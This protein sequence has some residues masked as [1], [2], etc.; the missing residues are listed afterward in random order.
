MFWKAYFWGFL[1]WAG[2]AGL[3]AALRPHSLT[4]VDWIDFVTFMPVAAAAV[5]VR[6]YNRWVLPPWVWKGLLFVTVFGKSM[7]GGIEVPEL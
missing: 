7:E 5:L 2:F 1:V 3:G 6:A 4:M